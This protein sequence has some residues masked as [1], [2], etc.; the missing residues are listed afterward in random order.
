MSNL[1]E[2]TRPTPWR[3]VEELLTQELGASPE[4]VFRWICPKPIASA[5]LAQVH[6]AVLK[7][8]RKVSG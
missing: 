1:F 5:S 6:E 8:G 3:Y 7:D 4:E 2:Q